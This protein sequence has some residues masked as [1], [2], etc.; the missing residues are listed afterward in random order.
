MTNSS[1]RQQ[2]Y[3]PPTMLEAVIT[4]PGANS[5]SGETAAVRRYLLERFTDDVSVLD[6]PHGTLDGGDVLFN[7]KDWFINTASQLLD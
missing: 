7:G 2:Y 3:F 6:L 1:A 5:R 4:K